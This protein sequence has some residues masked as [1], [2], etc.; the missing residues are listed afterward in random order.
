MYLFFDTETA[1]L[2]RRWDAPASDTRNWPRVVQLAWVACD[3]SGKP[4]APAAHLIKPE[5][6]VV[7]P[8]AFQRHGI[9]TE[10]ATAN[11]VP[12]RPVLASFLAA[13]EMSSVVVAHNV[14][15]DSRVVGSELVRAGMVNALESKELRCTMKESTD[16]CKLPG[17]RG[18]KWPTLSELHAVLF[19]ESFDNAHDAAADC[20]A[21]VRCFFALKS[22]KAIA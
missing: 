7:T 10:Y 11:G 22:R 20:L 6:F 12:L 14:N 1:D 16:Y 21:C 19:G 9:S 13:L 8:G 2:P 18:Y 15:F 5:G 4:E 17:G 3:S